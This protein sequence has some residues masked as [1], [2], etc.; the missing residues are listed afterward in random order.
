[1]FEYDTSGLVGMNNTLLT[2]EQL[3]LDAQ[4]ALFVQELVLSTLF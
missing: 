2:E 3:K 1:M 4:K